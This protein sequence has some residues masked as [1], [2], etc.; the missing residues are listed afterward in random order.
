MALI[1]LT[2]FVAGADALAE[3]VNKNFDII[4]GKFNTGFTDV[5]IAEG[6][7][8]AGSKIAPTSLLETRFGNNAVSARVLQSDLSAGAP[9]AAV[10]TAAH[11]KDGIITAA[12]LAP[13]AFAS[14]YTKHNY[15]FSEVL[16]NNAAAI[17]PFG[18]SP[19]YP[20][21]TLSLVGYYIQHTGTAVGYTTSLVI[22]SSNAT[23]WEGW[24]A[25]KEIGAGGGTAAG[26]LVLV[27][28]GV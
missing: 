24:L 6:A 7:N 2:R 21:A 25:L 19:T 20:R 17:V 14:L 1:G 5:D 9:L 3:E 10:A 11:I 8:I 16:A 23:N 22:N 15:A 13:L 28:C 4:A 26:T 12:K 27:F 18:I